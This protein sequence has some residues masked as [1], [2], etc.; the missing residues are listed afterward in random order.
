M[1]NFRKTINEEV[2]SKKIGLNPPL[3][4]SAEEVPIISEMIDNPTEN[5]ESKAKPRIP[6]QQVLHDSDEE[7]Q[8]E[9][10]LFSNDS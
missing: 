5:R 9:N 4:V 7:V 1:R 10:Y 3:I 8:P 2:F 6:Q